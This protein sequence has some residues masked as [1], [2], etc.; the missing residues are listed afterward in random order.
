MH[1]PS[2]LLSYRL[3]N[4]TTVF[5]KDSFGIKYP[6]KQRI[7]PNPSSRFNFVMLGK[8]TTEN[9]EKE[10]GNLRLSSVYNSSNFFFKFFNQKNLFCKKQNKKDKTKTN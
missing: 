9:L 5:Y 6:T 7:Q 3:R 4:I 10:F 1:E 2:Y 8:F